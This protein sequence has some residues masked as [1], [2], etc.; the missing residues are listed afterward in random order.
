MKRLFTNTAG[1]ERY[2]E[3]V[4]FW[5]WE[6]AELEDNDYIVELKAEDAKYEDVGLWYIHGFS[7]VNWIKN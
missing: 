6:D 2:E 7:E 3:G 1:K 4:T 5:A